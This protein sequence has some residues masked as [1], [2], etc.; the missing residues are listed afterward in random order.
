MGG[1]MAKLRK[2]GGEA[3]TVPADSAPEEV[4]APGDE[5]A[6]NDE[7]ADQE[8]ADTPQKKG[9]FVQ[10]LK[11]VKMRSF[12]DSILKQK[13]DPYEGMEEHEKDAQ[14]ELKKSKD[15]LDHSVVE[16]TY[17]KKNITKVPA[18]VAFYPNLTKLDLS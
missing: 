16:A 8:D 15:K 10:N 4:P 13:P 6:E 11:N 3:V 5:D 1:G 7:D 18:K 14:M 9:N 12:A 2:K 17:S